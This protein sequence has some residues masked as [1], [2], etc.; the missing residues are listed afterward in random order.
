MKIKRES[1]LGWVM[2]SWIGW[3]FIAYMV[4]RPIIYIVQGSFID[5]R[6][7]IVGLMFFYLGTLGFLLLVYAMVKA[8][9]KERA[10]KESKHKHGS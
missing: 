3:I 4:V 1:F 6:D 2:T 5:L 9:R 10:E 8:Y 7:A